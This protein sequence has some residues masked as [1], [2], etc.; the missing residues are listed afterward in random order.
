MDSVLETIGPFGALLLGILTLVAAA[1]FGL[2]EYNQLPKSGFY[3]RR[4]PNHDQQSHRS[5]IGL[6]ATLLLVG[7]FLVA[8]GLRWSL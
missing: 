8:E 2:W 7:L 6:F 5:A 3:L 1:A 4:R